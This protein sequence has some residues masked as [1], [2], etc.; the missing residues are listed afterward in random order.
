MCPLG[1][2][3]GACG[4]SPEAQ[5]G[6]DPLEFCAEGVH[7]PR[8]LPRAWGITGCHS[9]NP[10]A[11]LICSQPV[12]PVLSFILS[13]SHQTCEVVA[14]PGDPERTQISSLASWDPCSEGNPHLEM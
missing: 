14:V 4:L 6:R 5:P 1:T 10:S 7:T 2:V 8:S 9:L 12:I 11:Y 3:P 13:L